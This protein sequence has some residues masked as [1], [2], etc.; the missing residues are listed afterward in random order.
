MTRMERKALGHPVL[1]AGL[2]KP[3]G[4]LPEAKFIGTAED[5]PQYRV[6]GK[7]EFTFLKSFD[8]VAFLGNSRGGVTMVTPD[9]ANDL[10]A[11]INRDAVPVRYWRV[12]LADERVLDLHTYRWP[13]GPSFIEGGAGRVAEVHCIFDEVEKVWYVKR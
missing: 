6:A 11:P 13:D 4:D 1:A 7:H 9:F 3:I 8:T 5:S 10:S 12:I 2:D